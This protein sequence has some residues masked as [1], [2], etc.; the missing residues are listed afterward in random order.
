MAWLDWIFNVCNDLDA[1][2]AYAQKGSMRNVDETAQVLLCSI[3][4]SI[5]A[6]GKPHMRS[7]QPVRNFPNVAFETVP[8]LGSD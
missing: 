3:Q 4:C 2:L 7:T 8:M 6:L 1:V 5:Y